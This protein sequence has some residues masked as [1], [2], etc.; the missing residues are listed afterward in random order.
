MAGILAL[1]LA[2]VTGFA[3]DIH[4]V[5]ESGVAYFPVQKGEVR[6]WRF[7]R[8]SVWLYRWRDWNLDLVI[9]E[10]PISFHAGRAAASIAHGF[11][12]RVEEY[13]ARQRIPC[14]SVAPAALKKFACGK[15][16]AKKPEMIRA[17]QKLKLG[18]SDD[19]ECDA[20]WL[21]EYALANFA[22]KRE[23]A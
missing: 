12:T 5:R 10:A 11:G 1:D 13:C 14:Y 16:N 19:N 22:E 8:F 4:G 21:L 9:Y 3:T 23:T 20:L 17:A 2:T 15:G 18:V 6:G 7:V